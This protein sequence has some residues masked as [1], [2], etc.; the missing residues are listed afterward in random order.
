MYAE[1]VETIQDNGNGGTVREFEGSS[2]GGSVYV[3]WGHDQCPSTA[4]LM[5]SGRAGG[6]QYNQPAVLSYGGQGSDPH[7]PSTK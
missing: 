5:Y 6:S 1:N 3:R 7:L 4:Q 2:G